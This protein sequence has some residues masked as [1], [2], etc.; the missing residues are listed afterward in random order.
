[1]RRAKLEGR[2]LGRPPLNV[3][4]DALIRDRSRGQS[5]AVLAKTYQISRASVARVLQQSD[6]GGIA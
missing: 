3:D 1:M 6:S 4:R 5:L 2:R